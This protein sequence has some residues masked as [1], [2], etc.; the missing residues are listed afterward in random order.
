[1]VGL[2]FEL[3]L[4]DA[5]VLC[6]T[7]EEESEKNDGVS[8]ASCVY[9]TVEFFRFT[10]LQSEL[11]VTRRGGVDGSLEMTYIHTPTFK[12]DNENKSKIKYIMS[13]DLLYNTP[14]QYY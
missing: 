10:Y 5:K 7:S 13:K 1:M 3:I 11:T 4:S 12:I 8:F 2:E 14:T 9:Q 6:T